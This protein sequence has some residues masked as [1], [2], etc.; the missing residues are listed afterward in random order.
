MPATKSQLSV[1]LIGTVQT[2]INTVQASSRTVKE[3]GR[4]S[5]PIVGHGDKHQITATVAVAMIVE[6]LPM[7]ILYIGNQK[8][9]KPEYRFPSGFDI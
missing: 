4:K 2:A 3:E 6:M 1:S 7:Q 8:R 9:C 5:I